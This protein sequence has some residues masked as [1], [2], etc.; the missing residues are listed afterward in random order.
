MELPVRVS[1]AVS[2]HQLDTELKQSINSKLS[3][4]IGTSS[5]YIDYNASNIYLYFLQT[6]PICTFIPYS[7]KLKFLKS[8]KISLVNNDIFLNSF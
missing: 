2:E 3:I 1:V 7:F 8:I 4:C 5:N 6:L